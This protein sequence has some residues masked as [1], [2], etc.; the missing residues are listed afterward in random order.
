ME[1]ECY[2]C[3]WE[4][5]NFC[6]ATECHFFLSLYDF[7]KDK[8]IK[9][10]D[11]LNVSSSAK[12]SLVVFWDQYQHLP[13]VPEDATM[14]LP[15]MPTITSDP[16]FI[17]TQVPKSVTTQ[18]PSNETLV[19]PVPRYNE[20]ELL[21]IGGMGEV[22]K[23]LD[24][25]LN[26]YVAMKTL[27]KDYASN[28]QVRL[29]F[30]SEGQIAAQLEH[31]NIIPVYDVGVSPD[32]RPYFTMQII[33]GTSLK[34]MIKQ[35]H[36][37][38]EHGRWSTTE[39]GW[40]FYQLI[41]SFLQICNAMDYAHSRGVIHR[42]LKPANVMIGDHGEVIVVD[43]G[44]AKVHGEPDDLWRCTEP[45]I[46]EYN[47]GGHSTRMGVVAGTPSYMSPEQARGEHVGLS[48]SSDV[49][50]LGVMLYEI[51]TGA[52]PFP[53]KSATDILQKVRTQEPPKI[54]ASSEI[55]G[56]NYRHRSGMLLPVS[57]VKACYKAM[58][59][60]PED[61][62]PTA[63]ALGQV[64]RDWIAGV[65][66]RES[67][68]R[69]TQ[70]ALEIGRYAEQLEEQGRRLKTE[71]QGALEA[72]PSWESDEAKVQSWAVIDEGIA[73]QLKADISRIRGEQAL[74]GALTHKSDLLEA[75]LALA[76]LYYRQHQ[77]AELA[78][79]FD[80]A[81]G[82]EVRLEHHINALPNDHRDAITWKKY[83]HGEGTFSL[84]TTPTGARVY[85]EEF[86]L[87]N[88]RL[89][90]VD[91]RFVGT[92]PL[93]NIPIEMGSYRLRIEKQGHCQVVYPL[94]ISRLGNW[95]GIDPEGKQ[96]AVHLPLAEEVGTDEVYVPGGWFWCGGDRAL[97]N[98]LPRKRVWVD[99][100]VIG[101]HQ[102][103]NQQYLEYLNDLVCS[104]RGEEAQRRVPRERGGTA[105]VQGAR[106]YGIDDQG[107]FVL[108]P[109]ADGDVWGLQWPVMMIDWQSACAYAS[110]RAERDG[111]PWRL[112]Y[113]LEWEK[114][115][116]GVDGRL[117]PWGDNFDPSWC[118]MR[119]SHSGRMLPQPVRDNQSDK[120]PYGV[121]GMAGNVRQ[122]TLNSWNA[123]PFS[124]QRMAM[125][126]VDPQSYNMADPEQSG[127]QRVDRGGCWNGSYRYSRVAGRDFVHSYR[128][129]DF[130]GFRIARSIGPN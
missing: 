39:Q 117:Y 52:I 99:G 61:R 98:S 74:Q 1:I 32:G 108:R 43:W 59:K 8:F 63:G 28:E 84:H 70:E 12:K 67:A 3:L 18:R 20:V 101:R 29:R 88:R 17:H 127:P 93:I 102:I 123:S 36:L 80:V 35:V 126:A 5:P 73:L 23:V 69:I 94:H 72:I 42:D 81:S 33:K 75:H 83:L 41:D 90:P 47:S 56:G 34:E 119:E 87:K 66:R 116:R 21:G 76:E 57:L 55:N 109:D 120:S 104:G 92:T 24:I 26:R 82:I 53:G 51:L 44:I 25:E 118:C 58:S 48:F 111:L 27:R 6:Y 96:H 54:E 130:L 115:A 85:L 97:A 49:Y 65:K 14:M 71:G 2:Y 64:M 124:G 114:A 37:A 9:L 112:P 107:L 106:V 46:S 78:R 113:E 11:A 50:A 79:D 89:T 10:L 22:K 121:M 62:F 15:A 38:S 91:V 128:R 16:G 105:G 60:L 4:S 7:M 19:E 31:P 100:F 122:W 45:V 86:L 68:L 13:V 103:T 110:W 77:E 95:D 129:D 40:S 125:P 30:V